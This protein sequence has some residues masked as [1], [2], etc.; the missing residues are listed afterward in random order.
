MPHRE[1]FP[2]RGIHSRGLVVALLGDA[3][4]GHGREVPGPL[5]LHHTLGLATKNKCPTVDDCGD[6]WRSFGL[7]KSGKKPGSIQLG[8]PVERF[9]QG[10]RFVQS[11]L[12]GEPSPKKAKRRAL[13][14]GGPRLST[15][16]TKMKRG[17]ATSRV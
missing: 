17:W 10:T 6:F 1:R 15:Q 9:E 16:N 11:I 3:A 13:L 7:A 5:G 4:A 12:V 2:P 14:G 8:P